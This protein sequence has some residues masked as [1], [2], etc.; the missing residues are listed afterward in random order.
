M[1]TKQDTEQ[2]LERQDGQASADVPGALLNDDYT[3]MEFVV[4]VIQEYF[5]KDRETATQMMLVRPPSR[6]R[7]VRRVF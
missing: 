5:N 6:Q 3:P 2:L 7:S 4:A 1:A